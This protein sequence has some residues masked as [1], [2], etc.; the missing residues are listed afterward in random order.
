VDATRKIAELSERALRLNAE[1]RSA[2]AAE[3]LRQW[4]RVQVEAP[5]VAE[6]MIAIN[7]VF[8]KPA[9]VAVEIN[10]ELVLRSGE[11]QVVRKNLK[12]RGPDGYK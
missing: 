2:A 6:L 8:G 7:R 3:R 1:K 10:G 9:A 11:F 12:Y 5:D 4:Q